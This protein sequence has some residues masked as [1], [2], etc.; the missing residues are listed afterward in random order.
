METQK[1]RRRRE[2]REL[3]G[4]IRDDLTITERK[5]QS[6]SRCELA[7]MGELA[8]EYDILC[9]SYEQELL[10]FEMPTL[11]R[12][13]QVVWF[14]DVLI[15]EERDKFLRLAEG[16]SSINPEEETGGHFIIQREILLERK[17]WLQTGAY[18]VSAGSLAAVIFPRWKAEP[19]RRRITPECPFLPIMSYAE[20][21]ERIRQKISPP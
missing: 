13:A 12:L 21:I 11:L 9:S 3:E 2:C 8:R 15:D 4:K 19:I 18:L 1:E 16:I 10:I 14:G 7:E 6:I 17:R 5:G 20:Y